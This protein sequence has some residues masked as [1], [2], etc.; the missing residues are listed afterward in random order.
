MCTPHRPEYAGACTIFIDWYIYAP[1][2]EGIINNLLIYSLQNFLNENFVLS[3]NR[4]R[5]ELV[6]YY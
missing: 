5:D 4:K 6:S 2:R 1:Y 3:N